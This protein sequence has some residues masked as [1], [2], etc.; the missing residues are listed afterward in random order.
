MK[1]KPVDDRAC[2]DPDCTFYG[3]LARG[4][5]IRHSLIG[6]I[7]STDCG[8]PESRLLAPISFNI[9]TAAAAFERCHEPGTVVMKACTCGPSCGIEKVGGQAE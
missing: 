1:R 6:L 5:I 2:R 9:I 3:H 8:S 4:N 7:G